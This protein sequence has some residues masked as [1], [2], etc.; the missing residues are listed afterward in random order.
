MPRPCRIATSAG[1][2]ACLSRNT[3]PSSPKPWRATWCVPTGRMRSV[4]ARPSTAAASSI[5]WRSSPPPCAWVTKRMRG[6]LDSRRRANAAGQALM[7]APRSRREAPQALDQRP[8]AR[9]LDL[10]EL[11][12][13]REGKAFG[14][15]KAFAQRVDFGLPL[16]E[17]SVPLRDVG[18]G[19][20]QRVVEL[21]DGAVAFLGQLLDVPEARQQAL[22]LHRALGDH[23]A[24]FVGTARCAGPV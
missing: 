24:G 20:L 21:A 3:T 8:H 22:A 4:S 13:A 14:V 12:F 19:V 18:G 23:A 9:A 6:R 15:R 11:R 5:T 7:R 16:G 10:L 1:H 2:S 17:Q